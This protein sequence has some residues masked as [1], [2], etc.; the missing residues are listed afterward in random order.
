VQ[1]VHLPNDKHDFG[2][3]KR[4]PLYNFMAKYLSLNIK[5][6]HNDSAKIDESKITIEPEQAMYVFGDKGELLPANAIHGF[7]NLEKIF[8]DEIQK[9]K[10]TSASKLD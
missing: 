1:N 4:V 3:T 6:I 8:A 9:Q 10:P 7:E 2:I 5:A